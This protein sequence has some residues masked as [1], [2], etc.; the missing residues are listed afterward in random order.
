MHAKVICCWRSQLLAKRDRSRFR[1]GEFLAQDGLVL[2]D[3]DVLVHRRDTILPHRTTRSALK[4]CQLANL[5][6]D[7]SVDFCQH[8]NV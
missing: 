3:R 7:F 1:L 8:P 6:F 5:E 4:F 2:R